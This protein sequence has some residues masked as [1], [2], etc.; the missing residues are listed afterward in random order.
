MEGLA[1]IDDQAAISLADPS[2]IDLLDIHQED[3]IPS[4]LSTTTVHGTS[5]PTRCNLISGLQVQPL[6]ETST[7]TLPPIY[8]QNKLPQ[9]LHEIPSK[10]EVLSTPGLEHLANHFPDKEN[11]ETLII[12]G[13]N[14][15]KLNCNNKKQQVPTNHRLLQG[16]HWDGLS[17]VDPL[18]PPSQMMKCHLP[19]M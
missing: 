17:L 2:I 9:V 14:C 1:I 5:L 13:R 8:T 7:I 12:I 10:E 15:P 18:H 3:T 19:Q 6:D 16:P 4:T 11:W